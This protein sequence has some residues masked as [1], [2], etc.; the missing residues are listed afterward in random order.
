MSAQGE[1]GNDQ[2]R[3]LGCLDTL[4]REIERLVAANRNLTERLEASERRNEVLVAEAQQSARTLEGISQRLATS[5]V[6][7]VSPPAES[8]GAGGTADAK[9]RSP[10]R[11]HTP[12][13]A[14]SPRASP[15]A[16]TVSRNQSAATPRAGVPDARAAQNPSAEA[17]AGQESKAPRLLQG[18]KGDVVALAVIDEDT[19]AS[20]SWDHT[21]RVWRVS[22][23]ECVAILEGHTGHVSSICSV[24]VAQLASGSWDKSVRLWT[25][26]KGGGVSGAERVLR[27]H[28]KWVWKV[29]CVNTPT[30]RGLIVSASCDSTL[31]VWSSAT[32][33]CLHELKGHR[34]AV[35]GLCPVSLSLIAS[36][37]RDKTV[38]LWDV[39]SGERVRT[40][41]G[42]HHNV[43]SGIVPLGDGLIAT[44]C[45]DCV[46]RVFE[47]A[48]GKC[49]RRLTGHRDAI[50]TLARVTDDVV[51]SCSKDRTVRVWRVSTG[52]C[53]A[54][55]RGHKDSVWSV[56]RLRKDVIASCSRDHTV[57]VWRVSTGSCMDVLRGHQGSVLALARVGDERLCTA[58]ADASVRVWRMRNDRPRSRGKV[59]AV[60]ARKSLPA[61]ATPLPATPAPARA[62][63]AARA[64]S[65]VRAT[66][67]PVQSLTPRATPAAMSSQTT[68]RARLPFEAVFLSEM[69]KISTSRPLSAW[70]DPFTAE[71][72]RDWPNSMR[73]PSKRS[74]PPS[75]RRS[76]PAAGRSSA[77][78]PGSHRTAWR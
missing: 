63:P 54:V 39:L 64:Q 1:G 16:V 36:C 15:R 57:R 5:P 48:S 13:R 71:L 76:T 51:A 72:V 65:A 24:G 26:T 11:T 21:V 74:A 73:T 41:A 8:S 17:G 38:V 70:A 37:S 12:M 75:A 67:T 14:R 43:V 7:S 42:E 58:G 62:Q 34:G 6:R 18:H 69:K 31:R 45:W 9:V 49:V 78:K 66:A 10:R 20:G 27:G 59:R 23:G 19:I 29:M 56:C 33:E 50:W 77:A 35:I 60:P 47:T 28:R 44:A 2:D 61:A 40:I 3:A 55:L 68:P 22:T 53:I 4:R 52:A 32:G 25:V 30:V 46:V